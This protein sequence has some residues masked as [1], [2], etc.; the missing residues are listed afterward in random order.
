MI[1]IFGGAYQGKLEYARENFK[2]KTICDCSKGEEPDFAKAA[3][4][5]IEG[6]VRR[7]AREGGDPVAFFRE[8][9]DKWQ[10]CILIMTDVSQGIVPMDA[11]ERRYREL[12]GRLMTYLAGEAHQVIRVF[13]GLGKKVK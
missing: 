12:N 5:G 7:C 3:V 11:T 9:K 1:F 13:C 10:A 8:S 6:F 4:C 2:V